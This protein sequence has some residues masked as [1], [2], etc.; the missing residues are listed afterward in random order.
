MLK[1]LWIKRW[2]LLFI[3]VADGAFIACYGYIQVNKRKPGAMELLLKFE[4]HHIPV[5]WTRLHGMR[6]GRN[7]WVFKLG[8]KEDVLALMHQL[9][10]D[11]DAQVLALT[12]VAVVDVAA[13]QSPAMLLDTAVPFM[14]LLTRLRYPWLHSGMEKYVEV[15]FQPIIDLSDGGRIYAHEALCRLRTPDGELLTGYETFTLARHLGRVDA[16]DMALQQKA[17]QRKVSDF[18]PGVTLFLNVLP[19]T[20][21]QPEWPS[22]FLQWLSDYGVDHHEVGIEVV[23]SETPVGWRS[24]VM[25][26]ALKACALRW[27]IW[28]R[29]STVCRCWPWCA[30]TSSRSIVGW[31]MRRVA[32]GCARCCWRPW[33]QWPSDWVPQ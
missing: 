8:H 29:V 12:L 27:T 17:L 23:E 26:C 30:R 25:N 22:Q 24:A 16:L 31:C 28:G 10:Q 32:A 21:M 33:S 6:M 19:S 2:Q 1:C 7:V 18:E 4:G 15:H 11:T 9:A 14:V 5:S 13:Q 3:V 20:L